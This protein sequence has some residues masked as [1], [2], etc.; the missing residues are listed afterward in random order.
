[1]KTHVE[2]RRS[3]KEEETGGTEGQRKTA[4]V[5]QAERGEDHRPKPLV[6]LTRH[7]NS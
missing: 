5:R 7:K 3:Q 6:K 1:M 2:K 4:K